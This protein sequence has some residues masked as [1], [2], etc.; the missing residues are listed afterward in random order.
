[1]FGYSA[2]AGGS[3]LDYYPSAYAHA[4]GYSYAYPQSAV[5]YGSGYMGTAAAGGATG[6][7]STSQPTQQTY[8]LSDVA[9]DFFGK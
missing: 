9:P 1:M 4:N 8:H 3:S 6:S 5:G 7:C 2:A